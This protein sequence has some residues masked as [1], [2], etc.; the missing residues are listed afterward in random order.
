MKGSPHPQAPDLHLELSKEAS[1]GKSHQEEPDSENT[2]LIDSHT[3]KVPIYEL[4]L[5]DYK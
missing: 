3:L 4:T 5:C 2:N 1:D